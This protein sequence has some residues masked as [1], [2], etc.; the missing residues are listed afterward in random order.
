MKTVLAIDSDPLVLELYQ[1]LLQE[2]GY[3]VTLAPS[4]QEAEPL[5]RHQQFGAILVDHWTL[6]HRSG[7]QAPCR[8]NRLAAGTPILC[9]STFHPAVPSPLPGLWTA[10]PKPFSIEQLLS[11][12]SKSLGLAEAV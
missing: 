8:L 12:L 9:L 2:E 3:H 5:L 6:L 1:D 4:L 10:L 11:A 7:P